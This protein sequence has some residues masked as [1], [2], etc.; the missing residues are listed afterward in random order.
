MI[1]RP[2]R[3]TLFPYTTLFRSRRPPREDRSALPTAR[4]R[5]GAR[6]LRLDSSRLET[7]RGRVA[8]EEAPEA[9]ALVRRALRLRS[10]RHLPTT[11][12]R[13]PLPRRRD[14]A[15]PRAQPSLPADDPRPV[16]GGMGCPE[17]L[18]EP[19]A[20][21]RHRVG[22]RG[23]RGPRR[24]ELP[25]LELFAERLNLVLELQ[26]SARVD[27][28]RAN[29]QPTGAQEGTAE[30]GAGGRRGRGDEL[31][32]RCDAA[33]PDG[34]AGAGQRRSGATATGSRRA[35]PEAGPGALRPRSRVLDRCAAGAGG[36]WRRRGDAA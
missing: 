15:R 36:P 22:R 1:R 30:R 25:H 9:S 32:D 24:A 14:R 4:R 23:L 10:H 13:D 2:P 35:V 21:Q 18:V 28:E 16:A 8:Y 7:C 33:V 26:L 11:R 34:A 12:P 19:V 6:I 20:P 17:R 31:G 27:P 5:A 3:S 29:D